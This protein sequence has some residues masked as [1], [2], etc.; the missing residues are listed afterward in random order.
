MRL[1]CCVVVVGRLRLGRAG[2]AGRKRREKQVAGTD[3]NAEQ[4]LGEAAGDTGLEDFGGPWPGRQADGSLREA[5]EVL[6][7]TYKAN[8]FT[9]RG[10]RRNRRRLVQL[11]S[12]RLRV[13][14]AFVDH[15]EILEQPLAAPMIL[16]GLPRSGTSA[17]FNL[18]ACDPSARTQFPD[19]AEGLAPGDPDSGKHDPRRQMIKDYYEQARQKNPEF[20][21]IHFADADTPEECV[22]LHA[23]SLNGVHLGVEPMLEPYASWYRQQDL[24]PM[25]RYYR[26]QLQLLHWQR[27]G[28]RWLLK[29]PA[30]MWAIDSLLEVFPG[31]SVLW[32]HRDPLACTASIC[33]MTDAIPAGTLEWDK[34]KLGPLVMDF[35]ASSLERG[36]AVRD[37]SPA[38]RFYDVGHDD[39]VADPKL[40]VEGAYK[41]FGLELGQQA[42][43]S[44]RQHTAANPR[45]RHGSHDYRLEEWGIST[46]EVRERFAP[47]IDRFGISC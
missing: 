2:R 4:L 35:Y 15:P 20:T 26:A 12:T 44:M 37:K 33:S 24:L 10:R 13:E 8:P 21:K 45:G 28:E 42:T 25:Y 23:Y 40:L 27:P 39:F 5:L 3:F 17:L 46:G 9:E 38:G 6:C 1:G 43:D 41:H 7:E 31:A 18:L 22:L 29:A 14:K 11:L 36:L 16:T 32:S 19:P 47:Y 34:G 30:H